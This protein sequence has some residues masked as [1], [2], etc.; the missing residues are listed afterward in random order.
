[1]VFFQWAQA[2]EINSDSSENRVVELFGVIMTADSLRPV[3][4]ASV[5]VESDK[6]GTIANDKGIFS[7]AVLKGE[8]IKFSSIGYK[9]VEI[10]IP[11]NIKGNQYSVIQLMTEDTVYLPATIIRARPTPEE[12]AR[13]FLNTPVDEDMYEIARQNNNEATRRALMDVLP[14]DG[15]EAYSALMRQK[16]AQNYYKG[17]LPPMN[18]LN[19]FAWSDFIK[20]WKRG[21]YKSKN[22]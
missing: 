16:T 14:M 17:Q 15:K 22:Y 13:D 1:M 3:P 20:S 10:T 21:D 6:R 7:I 11:Q 9:D 12:F 4:A 2:Q 5:I 18:L 19:P 8:K